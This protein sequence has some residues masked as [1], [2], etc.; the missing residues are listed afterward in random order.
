MKAVSGEAV[1]FPSPLS[2]R[3]FAL[4]SI[5]VRARLG[6]GVRVHRGMPFSFVSETVIG[7]AGILIQGRFCAEKP[8]PS[9]RLDIL[10]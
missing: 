4:S 8:I 10:S 9:R 2:T 7:F 1:P 6:S 5:V 3:S